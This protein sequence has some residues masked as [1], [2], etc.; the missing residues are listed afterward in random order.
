V[1]PKFKALDEFQWI[2]YP[3]LQADM[4]KVL[5]KSHLNVHPNRLPIRVSPLFQWMAL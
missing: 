4:V 3:E 5:L 1:L 2:G